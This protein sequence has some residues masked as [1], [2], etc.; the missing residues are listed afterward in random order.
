MKGYS[1]FR[2]NENNKL[3]YIYIEYLAEKEFPMEIFEFAELESLYISHTSIEKVPVD[4]TQMNNLKVFEINSGKLNGGVEL[5]LPLSLKT[6]GLYYC[7][8]DSIKFINETNL[9]GLII[10]N[11]KIRNLNESLCNHKQLRVIN[12]EGNLIEDFDLTCLKNLEVIMCANC[13][14]KDTVEIKKRHGDKILYFLTDPI[15]NRD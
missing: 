15:P 1:Y 10:W 5:K 12:F 3:R 7:K 2:K 8:I 9:S 6:L 14:L 11:N 4:W 13:P